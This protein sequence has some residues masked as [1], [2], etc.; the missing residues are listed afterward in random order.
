MNDLPEMMKLIL[1]SVV[2][3]GEAE[4]KAMLEA[5]AKRIAQE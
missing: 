5:E 1:P 4:H 3:Q 2:N